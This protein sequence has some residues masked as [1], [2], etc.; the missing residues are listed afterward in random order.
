[1]TKSLSMNKSLSIYEMSLDYQDMLRNLMADEDIT[2]QIISDMI[3]AKQGEFKVK[4]ESLGALYLNLELEAE[5]VETVY[6]RLK[7]R[8]QRLQKTISTF[9]DSL[10]SGMIAH[11]ITEI[12]TS[13]F[14]VTLGK[15]PNKTIIDDMNSI[16]D[17]FIRNNPEAD[18]TAIKKSI[19]EGFEVPGAHLESS[20]RLIIK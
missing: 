2:P 20:Q 9:K 5:K 19:E 7:E 4:V 11:N 8:H 10:L 14:K 18:K 1:M 12:V 17:E 16:P 13:E 6:K 15:N 3:E